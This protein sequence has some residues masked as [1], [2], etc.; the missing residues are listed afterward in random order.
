MI[1][2]E[3][4]IVNVDEISKE[5]CWNLKT[6]GYRGL[7]SNESR[8]L[9][10]KAGLGRR[11]SKDRTDK[12]QKSRALRIK[13]IGQKISESNRGQIRSNEARKKISDRK[14]EKMTPEIRKRISA[15]KLGTSNPAWLGYVKTPD[16][17]FESS[18]VAALYYG[19]T[20]KTIRDRIKS[21][22]P[23]FNGWMFI[24]TLDMVSKII[25]RSDIRGDVGE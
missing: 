11:Y 22:N 25:S 4:Q 23:K 16:G 9:I 12:I 19:K 5:L 2:L 7:P 18:M 6:G 10:S 17:I 8:M 1:K 3:E 13:E 20:D 21:I 15:A 14:K 24:K